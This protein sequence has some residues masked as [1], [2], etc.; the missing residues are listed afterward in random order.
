[1]TIEIVINEILDII[2]QRD[3][4]DCE[5]ICVNDCSP[6]KVYDVLKVLASR[7]KKIKVL[8]LSK[9]MGKHAAVMA[10]YSVANGDYI[11]NLDDDFQSPVNELWKLVDMITKSD[12]DLVTAMYPQKKQSIF[13]NFGSYINHV[14]QHFMLGKPL[15][16]R[17]ENFNIMKRYIMDE[18]IKYNRPYPYITGLLLRV[19]RNVM[20]VEMK[21]RR[22]ADD[23]ATGFTFRKSISLWANGLTAFS[24][25]PL[26]LAGI[27]GS[28]LAISGFIFGIYLFVAWLLNPDRQTGFTTIVAINLLG[29]GVTLLSLGIIGEYIGRIYICIN[30]APQYVIKNSINIDEN[31]M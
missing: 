8:D 11:V 21:Q 13:K 26:R 19:T 6:D 17:I 27:I 20:Q 24:V 25:K 18:M 14:M 16:L 7:N 9:N 4:Y 22:R 23:N 2:S 29:F 31:E 1:M 10:G 3:N 30:E 12:C 5:I 15:S 28:L